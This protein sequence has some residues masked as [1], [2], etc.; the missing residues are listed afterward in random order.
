MTDNV[1]Y[2]HG[3]PTEVAMALRIGFSEHRVCEQLLEANKI[4]ARRFIVEGA[5]LKRHASLLRTLKDRGEEIILD[6]NVAELS[7]PGRF[8]G[9]VSSA[10][11]SAEDRPLE[12]DDFVAGTNRSV[13]EPIARTAV[14]TGVSAVMAPTHFLGDK[15]KNWLD[16][17]ARACAALRTSLDKEGGGAIGIDYSVIV[18]YDQIRD[19]V[20]RRALIDRLK[21]CPFDQLWLRV[22]NFGADATGVGMSR[23]IEASYAFSELGKPILADQVGGLASLAITAFGG[24]SGFSQGLEGKQKFNAQHWDQPGR[25]GGGGEKRVFVGGLDKNIKVSDLKALFEAS[26]TS[27]QIFGCSDSTCCGDID[28]MLNEPAAHR[29]VQKQRAVEHLSRT[30]SANRPDIFLE[31][32]LDRDFAKAKRAIKLKNMTEE[33][34]S[35]VDAS[36]QRLARIQSALSGLLERNGVPDAPKE[37][38]FRANGRSPQTLGQESL[39]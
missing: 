21:D 30:P 29:V 32:I 31:E 39:S 9:A 11:W 23:M 10:P 19:P 18:T 12:P 35:T 8:A 13:I 26:R 16:I 28:K 37:A 22:A 24:F 7:A 3:R 27:R 17:D 14:Q 36:A 38:T 34:R 25:G 4:A 1:V 2:L 15:S 6:T 33:L 20:F 5:N